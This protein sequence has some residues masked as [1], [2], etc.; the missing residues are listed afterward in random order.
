MRPCQ[1]VL[2][3][4]W[5]VSKGVTLYVCSVPGL[6]CVSVSCSRFGTGTRKAQVMSC[7]YTDA[8]SWYT[9]SQL[10]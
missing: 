5:G 2:Q 4:D 3:G 7:C 1:L 9:A 10:P 6:V 8:G